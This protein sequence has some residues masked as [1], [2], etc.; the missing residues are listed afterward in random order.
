[1]ADINMAHV[2]ALVLKEIK[3]IWADKSVL[4]IAFIIPLMLVLLYGSG[5]RMDIKPISVGL[6]SSKLDNVV[7]KEI[8]FA[9]GGSEYFDLHTLTN[10]IDAKEQLRTHEI[11]A[12]I[13]LPDNLAQRVYNNTLQVMITINGTDAQQATL[14]RSYLEGVI[15][16]AFNFKGLSRQ[17]SFLTHMNNQNIE[18]SGSVNAAGAAA[19]DISVISRN[20]FNEENNSTWYLMAGQLICVVTIMSALMSS[21]VIAREAERGTLTGLQA[22]NVTAAELLLSKFIPYYVLS[23]MGAALSILFAMIFYELPFRGNVLLYIITLL[24]YLFVTVMMGLLISA[25]TQNQFLSSE[26]AIILSFLP[27]ILLSGAL[28]DLRSIPTIISIIAQFFPPTYA[29]SSSKICMLS[30]G[31]T[32]V[33]LRNIGILFIFGVVFSALC[34]KVLYKYFKRYQLQAESNAGAGAGTGTGTGSDIK[35]TAAAAAADAKVETK[36]TVVSGRDEV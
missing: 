8:A 16:S 1:M 2:K 30:G 34:Y 13:T 35:S 24:V 36:A 17:I 15:A 25:V 32:D 4:V 12:Y 33:L 23:I 11:A 29:V 27:A 31:S 26:Y 22:T 6:V 28:F 14:T 9:L 5:I 3:Q 20:W 19:S 10:E 21:I 18:L 7:T